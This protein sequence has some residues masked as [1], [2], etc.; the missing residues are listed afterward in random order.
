MAPQLSCV[1]WMQGSEVG[2]L[3]HKDALEW[4][5][6]RLTDPDVLHVGHHIA[7]DMAVI[8]AE[9]PELLPL[10]FEAYEANRVTDTMIR[11]MLLDNAMGKYRGFWKRTVDSD[12]YPTERWVKVFYSLD[13][14]Y[15][16]VTRKRLDKDTYRLTYGELRGTPLEYWPQGAL[17]YPIQD[18]RAT[19][20]IYDWQENLCKEITSK[21]SSSQPHIQEPQPLFD[22]FS[23]ARAAFWIQ[24]MSIWGL[25]TDPEMVDK[26][27]LEVVAKLGELR[28][29]LKAAGL[30][31]QD[32]TRDTKA[33][34]E[35]MVLVRGGVDNCRLTEKKNIQL[36]EDAC[37]ESGDPILQDY[38]EITSLGAVLSKDLKALRRGKEMPIH[39]RFSSFLSTGRTSSSDPNVQNVRRLPGIRECFVPRKGKVFISADYDG[40]ELRTLAQACLKL[41]GFSKLAEAL[42]GGDDP[43]LRVA[44]QILGISYQDAEQG[45]A[46]K[47]VKVEN[48]RQT[49]KVANFGFPGGLGY[50]TLVIFAK[51]SYNVTITVEEA[52][53]LKTQW[54]KTFPEMEKYFTLISGFGVPDP[55]DSDWI[56]HSIEQV[57]SKRLRGDATYTAACNSYFQGLGADAT[58]NAGFLIAKECYIDKSSP[59]FGCRTVNYIHDEFI[60]ECEEDRAHEAAYRLARLMV[61]GAAPYLPDV[62]A[63]VSAPLVSRCWSKEAK[64]MFNEKG[65]LIPWEADLEK[66]LEAG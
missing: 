22:Q 38:S 58:K 30:V 44:A 24:L 5:R 18:A 27:E 16:R 47:G 19:H 59:L 41:V 43:H 53:A 40:L 13:D 62:P 21:Y 6:V 34:Q 49:A 52:K 4:F 7:Y 56:L 37:K 45:R 42:N 36:D 48:A 2:L 50:E 54:L 57:F 63:T 17:D 11:Q 8:A 28:E 33:A 3:D 64:P 55:E 46:K 9:H 15:H 61:E 29:S 66:K 31:R 39:S 14:C 25:R 60:L 65:R 26:L 32:G 35:R 10:I 1:S 20:A 12:G 23:Q 51:K